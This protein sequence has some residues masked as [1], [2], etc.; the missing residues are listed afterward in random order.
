MSYL[1]KISSLISF[2][3]SLAKPF[4]RKKREKKSDKHQSVVLKLREGEINTLLKRYTPTPFP[5]W[6]L[7]M[8]NKITGAD[9]FFVCSKWWNIII[10]AL[11]TKSSITQVFLLSWLS[12]AGLCWIM[13]SLRKEKFFGIWKMQKYGPREIILNQSLKRYSVTEKN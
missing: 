10:L 2:T 13:K 9:M 4:G 11:V 7:Y 3:L 5:H 1:S 12:F 8:N 6:F